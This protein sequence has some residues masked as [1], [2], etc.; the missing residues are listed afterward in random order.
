MHFLRRSAISLPYFPQNADNFIILSFFG[1]QNINVFFLNKAQKF[2][3]PDLNPPVQCKS[4]HLQVKHVYNQQTA[5]IKK[6]KTL[7]H[8][9]AIVFQYLQEVPVYYH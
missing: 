8:V 6:Q 1:S 2:Q 9:S 7:L 3:K 4:H 5:H